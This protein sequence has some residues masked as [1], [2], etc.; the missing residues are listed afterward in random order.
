MLP[1]DQEFHVHDLLTTPNIHVRKLND[2]SHFTDSL[3]LSG[4][5]HLVQVT[6]LVSGRTG[7]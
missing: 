6:Q 2:Y 5:G 3:W 7:T 1:Q 4:L